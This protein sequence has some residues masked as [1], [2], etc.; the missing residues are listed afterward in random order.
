METINRIFCTV[1][2]TVFLGGLAYAQV[3][4]DADQL[5]QQFEELK[6][7]SNSVQSGSGREYK[8]I[9]LQNMNSLWNDVQE[10][11]AASSEEI[12]KTKSRVDALNGEVASLSQRVEA[13]QASIQES[14]F[15]ATHLS[16][17][18]I[19][20]PKDKFV[21]TFWI[22]IGVLIVLLVVAVYQY[23][24]TRDSTRRTQI[25][26][27]QLQEEMEELRKTS[28]EK[29]RRL[30]RELQTERNMIEELGRNPGY[31]R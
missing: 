5:D 30:R 24:L 25:N 26:F 18:G 4:T 7:N 11:M 19:D 14:E 12:E 17:L 22:S 16:V 9:D 29:E 1:M 6:S 8:V 10:L 21:A 3:K 2:L 20:I 31:K 27:M 23:K 15:A 28:L 13:Q